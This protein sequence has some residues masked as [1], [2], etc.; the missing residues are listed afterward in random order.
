MRSTPI[1]NGKQ[2]NQPIRVITS[3]SSVKGH[4]WFH[5]KRSRRKSSGAARGWIMPTAVPR[6]DDQR[7]PP[8][9]VCQGLDAARPTRWHNKV[10][11][12]SGADYSVGCETITMSL[13]R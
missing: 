8:H 1:L 12:Y 4:P 3:P 2:P 5:G 13:M 9:P 10:S 7:A 6:Q 11:A